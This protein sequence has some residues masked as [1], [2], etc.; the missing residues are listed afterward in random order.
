MAYEI[1]RE[2]KTKG[3]VADDFRM[4]HEIIGLFLKTL[5]SI[6]IIHNIL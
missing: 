2:N 1:N 5:K 3:F 4:I 6:I